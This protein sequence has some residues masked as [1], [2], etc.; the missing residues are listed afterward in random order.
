MERTIGFKERRYIE[1]LRIL[2]KATAIDCL[3]D[4][5]FDRLIDG[6]RQG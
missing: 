3:I 2:T 4:D 6:I 5:R 1:E